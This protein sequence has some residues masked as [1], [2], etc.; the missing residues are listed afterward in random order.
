MPVFDWGRRYDRDTLGQ[1]TCV[2]AVIVTIMLI[3][4]SL[5]YA[6]LAGLPAETGHLCLDRCRSCSTRSSAPAGRWPSARGGGLA[7]DRGSDRKHGRARNARTAACRRHAG[8]PVG[9]LPD[10][11]GVFRLGF[12]A[13]FLSHPVIAGFIT[14]S[15]ILIAMPA[16]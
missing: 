1:A 8:L 2:A 11:A 9:R 3:P 7:D 6:L 10:P 12:L 14:A 15:G 16:S 13:N 5:A 4:Q